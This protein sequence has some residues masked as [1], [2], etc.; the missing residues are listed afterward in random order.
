M[1]TPERMTKS[2]NGLAYITVA[3]QDLDDLTHLLKSL[4]WT[5]FDNSHLSLF[6]YTRLAPF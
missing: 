4:I 3:F 5:V 2:V 6:I 1:I